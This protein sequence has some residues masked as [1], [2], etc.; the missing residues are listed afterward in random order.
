[1]LSFATKRNAVKSFAAI[2]ANSVTCQ[3]TEQVIVSVTDSDSDSPAVHFGALGLGSMIY[4]GLLHN[5]VM[6]AVDL[7]ADWHIARKEEKTAEAS[8]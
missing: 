5:H 3:A 1:M 4:Y 6:D 2:A 7:V 8:A